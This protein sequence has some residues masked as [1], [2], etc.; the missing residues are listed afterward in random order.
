VG[1]DA[2][3]H[4]LRATFDDSPELY[5]RSRAVAPP[6]LFDDLVALARLGPGARLVEIGCG[7]GQATLPLA[8]RGFEIVGIELGENLAG[9][10]R[11]KLAPF[12]RVRIVIA[13]FE[14]W[15]PAGDGYDGVVSFNAFHWVDPEVRYAKSA[16]VLRPGGALAVMGSAFVVHDG[17][18][19]TWLALEEDYEAVVGE[20]EPRPHVDTLKD[21]S[22]E[23]EAGGWFRNV[24]LRRYVWDVDFD[25]D[26]YLDR[27]ST[28]SWHGRLAEDVRSELFERIRRRILAAPGQ[29]IAPT[30]A[31]VLYVAERS[32]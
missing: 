26:G 19:A 15:Q 17:A 2:E 20:C 14:Q 18:D 31:A 27:L 3:R 28:S 8:E 22:G 7:T 23:F 32:P 6:R 24:V 29:S 21:R 30:T 5:D 11:R 25:A 12:P 10:A 1:D 4:L 13:S 9:L 16:E